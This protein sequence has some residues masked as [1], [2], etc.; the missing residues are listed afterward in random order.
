MFLWPARGRALKF[1]ACLGWFLSHGIFAKCFLIMEC[2]LFC[3]S[4]ARQK[5]RILQKSRKN[6]LT[7][8]WTWHL[9]EEHRCDPRWFLSSINPRQHLIPPDLY[10]CSGICTA[11]GNTDGCFHR[12]KLYFFSR[13]TACGCSLAS[14]AGLWEPVG[15]GLTGKV[16]SPLA[17]NVKL[18]AG[19]QLLI[20]NEQSNPSA[21]IQGL[22]ESLLTGEAWKTWF[23]PQPVVA[24]WS[25]ADL[26]SHP[27]H[28]ESGFITFI[29][30]GSRFYKVKLSLLSNYSFFPL[31][32]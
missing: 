9:L 18:Y 31:L 27:Q 3:S 7:D 5:Q 11:E 20:C 6:S 22:N 13:A 16:S 32:I 23:I 12:D 25:E 17:L 28:Q 19:N 8:R 2:V 4:F 26:A 10:F 29:I 24:C 21:L 15:A 30:P 14:P 1:L